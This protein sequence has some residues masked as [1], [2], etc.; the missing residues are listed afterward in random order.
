VA[1]F[2]LEGAG[3]GVVREAISPREEEDLQMA[4]PRMLISRAT[5]KTARPM[6]P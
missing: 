6:I 3:E 2:G 5:S 4:K 1:G